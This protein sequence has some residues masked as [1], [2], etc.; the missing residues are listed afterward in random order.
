MIF[1]FISLLYSILFFHFLLPFSTWTTSTQKLFISYFLFHDQFSQ[2]VFFVFNELSLNIAHSTCFHCPLKSLSS[3]F[4]G[5]CWKI[6]RWQYQLVRWKTKLYR[7]GV[8]VMWIWC[9]IR[10]WFYFI[11]IVSTICQSFLKGT[12]GE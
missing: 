10:I 9:P 12:V 8:L 2:V 3:T 11:R 1:L 5:F 7:I 6:V 4:C